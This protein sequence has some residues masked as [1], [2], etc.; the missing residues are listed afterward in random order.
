M[1]EP[2]AKVPRF[3]VVAPL[4]RDGEL[5]AGF[6]NASGYAAESVPNIR[7]VDG[8]DCT[9]VLGLILTDEALQRGDFETFKRVVHSQPVWSDLPV[10]LL[11]SSATEPHVPRWRARRESR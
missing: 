10:L 2:A 3:L 11:T 1:T 9:A 8:Q 4:G 6:L 5:I 7:E